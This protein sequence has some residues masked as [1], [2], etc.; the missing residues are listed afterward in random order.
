MKTLFIALTIIASLVTKT[1]FAG[2]EKISPQVLKSFK[3]TFENAREVDWSE[4]ASLYKVHFEFSGQYITAFY[5][6]EGNLL[7]VTR[8]ITATQ[9]PVT[10]Q[11]AFNKDYEQYWITDLFEVSTD[12]G[13]EYYLTVENADSKLV[14]KASNNINWSVYKKG[15]KA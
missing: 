14:L 9:L 10:L 15:S 7:A 12:G 1:S 5:E 11:A 3:T 8:N 4:S 6:K 13:T 2:E